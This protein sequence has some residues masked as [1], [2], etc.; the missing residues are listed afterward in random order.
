MAM[1]IAG[2]IERSGATVL[3]GGIVIT[4]GGAMLRGFAEMAQ[5][6]TDLPVRVAAPTGTMGMDDE[7]RGPNCA[8]T[9]GLLRWAART[10]RR[11]AVR[12]NGHSN[13]NG[14]G[15]VGDRFSRW[16]RELF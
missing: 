13:G 2:E 6:V 14:H 16:V 10:G 3:P 9:V 1:L 12:S 11:T 8:T 4:G 7:L 15:G 5:Q